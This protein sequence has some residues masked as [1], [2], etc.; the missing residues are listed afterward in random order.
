M[1]AQTAPTSYPLALFVQVV[2]PK[3]VPIAP[4]S[5]GGSA[6]SNPVGGYTP[7]IHKIG[8]S[9]WESEPGGR[10]CIVRSC[11]ALS[12][13]LQVEPQGLG[14]RHLMG[15]GPAADPTRIRGLAAREGGDLFCGG[16]SGGIRSRSPMIVG[17]R[18]NRLT[19]RNIL[20]DRG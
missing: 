20:D 6:G 5:Q 16:S 14:P 11:P 10:S 18:P 9:V 3:E 2:M 13:R 12:G 17:Y 8:P 7:D 15:S 4:P 19:C 1:C